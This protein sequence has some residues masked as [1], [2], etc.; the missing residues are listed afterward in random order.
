[1]AA[2]WLA[3]AMERRGYLTVCALLSAGC[4]GGRRNESGPRT[5]PPSPEGGGAE[6]TERQRD[7]Q[8]LDYTVESGDDGRLAVP[9][10]VENLADDRRTGT[11]VGEA[12]VDGETFRVEREVS[13]EG[14]TEATITLEFD[15]S[16]DE[17]T[18]G[19][20]LTLDWA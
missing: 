16:Y 15:V 8:I 5:P 9:V 3:R 1:M 7:L 20:D 19:G 2:A 18:S 14:D 13:L 4:L 6:K 17:F 12:T 11:L 10:T